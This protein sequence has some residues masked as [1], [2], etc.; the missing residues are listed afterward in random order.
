MVESEWTEVKQKK[1]KFVPK[2]T[3]EQ[4]ATYGGIKKGVLVAGPIQGKAT[5]YG[6]PGAYGGEDKATKYND[7][8]DDW[9]EVA[10][11][12]PK[13]KATAIAEYDFGVFTGSEEVK[14]E[15][16]SH[17]CATSV[18]EARTNAKLTQG[19]LAAKVNEKP[20]VIVDL[21]KGTLRYNADLINRIEKVLGV[22]INR[23]RKPVKTAKK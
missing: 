6:G 17:T 13:D 9:Q 21:E 11:K 3:P 1:K 19:Q 12:F 8:E 23:G 7:D 15:L 5:K 10:Q 18:A 2:Q 20:S 22:Q 14:H 16:V 4:A